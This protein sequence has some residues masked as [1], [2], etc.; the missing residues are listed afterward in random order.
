MRYTLLAFALICFLSIHLKAQKI[1][2][3]ET[4]DVNGLAITFT[5]LNKET[6]D[7]KGKQFDRYKVAA[8]VK[9]NSSKSLNIRLSAFPQVVS[10]I[11]IVE[12]DCINATGAKLTSKKIELKMKAQIINVTYWAYDKNGK[13]VSSIIPVTGSYYFDTGDVVQD[14]AIFIVPQGEK[15]DVSIRTLQ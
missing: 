3:G 4:V 12:L 10:N 14:N 11:G 1:A 2:D 6:V 9:N 7:V 13:Y 15:P 8:S 5:I